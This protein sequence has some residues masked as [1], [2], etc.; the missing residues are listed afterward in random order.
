[1]SFPSGVNYGKSPKPGLS[2]DFSGFAAQDRFRSDRPRSGPA[3]RS[4]PSRHARICRSRPSPGLASKEGPRALHFRP[5]PIASPA[6]GVRYKPVHP[7]NCHRDPA[8]C[9]WKGDLAV[10]ALRMTRPAVRL[11]VV[12][13]LLQARLGFSQVA[14]EYQVKAVFLFHFTQFTEW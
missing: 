4:C 8:F 5:E 2:A 12:L 1:G 14:E 9:L 13:C 11:F 6:S 10:L 3:A 7:Y